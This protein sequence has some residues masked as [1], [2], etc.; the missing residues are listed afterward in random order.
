MNEYSEYSEYTIGN[1]LFYSSKPSEL[2][3]LT[4]GFERMELELE[5]ELSKARASSLSGIE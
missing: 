4:L 3:T 1:S 2:M 5:L